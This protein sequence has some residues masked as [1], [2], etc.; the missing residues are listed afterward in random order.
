MRVQFAFLYVQCRHIGWFCLITRGRVLL[1]VRDIHHFCDLNIMVY[2]S[3]IN[4][5]PKNSVL[6]M[7]FFGRK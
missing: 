3:L 2:L 4:I 1:N 7:S 6:Y 5:L